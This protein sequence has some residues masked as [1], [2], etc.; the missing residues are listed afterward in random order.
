MGSKPFTAIQMIGTQRS[1]SNLLRLML[2]QLDSVSAPHPPHILERFVPLLPAYGDLNVQTNFADLASDICKLIEYN[3]VPWDGLQLSSDII[4][5]RCNNNSV[6]E[7]FRVIYELRAQSQNAHIWIC[8]SMVNI[9]FVHL[10]EPAIK[11]LY[12]HLYRDGRDVA[13]SFMKAIF[14]EKHV[15]FIA[16]QWREEQEMAMKLMGHISG[17]RFIQVSYENLLANPESEIKRLCSFIGANYDQ[18]VLSFFQ[19]NESIN[20][21]HSGEMWKN[22]EKP[23]L[24]DNFNKFSKEMSDTDIQ[25]FEQVAGE[26]LLKLGYPLQFPF[27]NTPFEPQQIEAFSAINQKRKEEV[28]ATISPED[29]EKRKRQD[30]LLKSIRKRITSNSN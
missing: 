11:P 28:R 19:S 26:T 29:L 23:I 17:N 16:K 27:N 13:L 22:V 14:G 18:S 30:D 12:L 25:M 6:Q 15:Y 9:Q 1:G 2:N 20:T 24:K 5:S 10:L 3:P 21:A 7:I 4:T 8:K